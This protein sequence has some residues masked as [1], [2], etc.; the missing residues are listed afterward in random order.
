M[1]EVV[2]VQG[3]PTR[4]VVYFVRGSESGR[5]KIGRTRNAVAFRMA[6]IAG[7]CSE[8]IELLGVVLEDHYATGSGEY[9]ETAIHRRLAD[10]RL[11]GEWFHPHPEVLELVGVL[12]DNQRRL[13]SLPSGARAS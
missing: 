7:M 11:H 9:T 4:P 2:A 13:G 5:I 6:A 10:H 8:P 1:A 3:S 12:L